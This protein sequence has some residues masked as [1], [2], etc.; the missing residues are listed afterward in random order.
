MDE[1]TSGGADTHAA[2]GQG[3][4]IWW[5][6]SAPY[7]RELRAK[8]ELE[9]AGV[10]CFV[11]MRYRVVE[12]R[13]GMKTRELQPAIRNLVFARATTA[14]M[15]RAK[16]LISIIQYLTR[17]ESGRNI[18]ITVPENEMRRFMA[19]CEAD[20]EHSI[21][22]RPDEVDLRRADPRTRI[23]ERAGRHIAAVTLRRTKH[24]KV[25]PQRPG[26]EIAVGVAA[27]TAVDRTGVHAGAAA[28]ALEHVAVRGIGQPLR[29]AVVDDDD[30]DLP[31][32]RG[33]AVE[34]R[35]GRHGLPRARAGQ[36]AREDPQRPH[37]GNHLLKPHDGDVQVGERGAQVGVALVRADGQRP[38]RGHGEVDARHRDIGLEELRPQGV[39]RRM[40]QVGRIAVA[41]FGAHL[42]LEERPNL[43]APH[44]DGRQHDVARGH[45][46]QLHDPLAEVAL[47][48]LHAP[49]LEIGRQ[50]ALLREHRLALDEAVSAVLAD[51]L[52]D[53]LVH[54]GAV[55]RPM[56]HH[57]V[58]RGVAL[59]LLEVVAQTAQRVELDLRGGAP[60]RLPLGNALHHAVALLA[61]GVE[62]PVVPRHAFGVGD[63]VPC[64]FGMRTHD[65]ELRISTMWMVLI[66]SRSWS[67]MPCWC[68][69][70]EASAPVMYSAPVA[71][72][73][74]T[75]S[76]PIATD[77]AFSS[78]E[79]MPPKPQHSSRRSGST[80]STPSTIASRSR[81]FE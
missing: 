52:P 69:R 2:A 13:G 33:P 22:L 24:P 68:I 44:A 37:V 40:R 46:Q 55:R 25:D 1:I 9:Q 8:R 50:P 62:R 20:T 4:I 43:L 14:D 29:P 64:G 39:P 53:D 17:P 15:R 80:T 49:F 21:Y 45:V 28:Q 18:P 30:M 74:R 42:A 32:G 10:E 63:E 19:V 31:P 51:E 7:C 59:E 23:T 16:R 48:R 61:H 56:H 57:A 35:V 79:N 78:T 66:G 27:R 12:R 6:L 26:N 72:W 65:C 11:P 73:R 36:Q 70:H 41:R 75:L 76:R 3:D 67:M 58:G 34:R 38:G 47:D 60:Q 5:A 71:M 77:T 81:N 54:R